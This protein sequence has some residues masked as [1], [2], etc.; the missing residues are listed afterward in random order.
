MAKMGLLERVGGSFLKGNDILT[1]GDENT[2][3][4]QSKKENP[5]SPDKHW[6]TF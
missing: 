3:G 2:A 5:I 1:R 6:K 4:Q